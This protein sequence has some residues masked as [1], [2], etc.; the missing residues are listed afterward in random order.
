MDHSSSFSSLLEE[1]SK[2]GGESYIVVGVLLTMFCIYL[3]KRMGFIGKKNGCNGNGIDI[4]TLKEFCGAVKEM[5]QSCDKLQ[6]I[7]EHDFG[8]KI[9]RLGGKISGFGG[10]VDLLGERVDFLREAIRGSPFNDYYSDI[11]GKYI[12]GLHTRKRDE[13]E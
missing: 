5:K 3:L 2:L 8:G 11:R 9:D 7:I 1:T 4:K 6:N 12:G 13:R 10:K